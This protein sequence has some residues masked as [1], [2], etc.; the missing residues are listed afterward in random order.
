LAI[1][2]YCVYLYM[3]ALFVFAGLTLFRKGRLSLLWVLTYL[4]FP[5]ALLILTT[6]YLGLT[7][8][9]SPSPSATVIA[10]VVGTVMCCL[11]IS[12]YCSAISAHPA[13]AHM[14]HQSA[15]PSHV[16]KRGPYR[17]VRHPIYAAYMLHFLGA[18]L[19]ASNWFMLGVALCGFGMLNFTARKEEREFLQSPVAGEY[20]AYMTM[21]GRFL[22][23]LS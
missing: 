21:T 12:V 7:D 20:A 17:Y 11:A 15:S 5:L 4:P 3:H 22:P 1:E 10:N 18:L 14:W 9:F 13:P 6:T 23:R 8:S 2:T 16:T 19:V